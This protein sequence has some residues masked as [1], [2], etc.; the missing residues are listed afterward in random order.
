MD[1]PDIRWLETFDGY[2]CNIADS[3]VE[4]LIRRLFTNDEW[5]W[6]YEIMINFKTIKLSTKYSSKEIATKAFI[7]DYPTPLHLINHQSWGTVDK[8]E[9]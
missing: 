2:V 6:I 7:K 8:K 3:E 4:V 1:I 5:T 9:D